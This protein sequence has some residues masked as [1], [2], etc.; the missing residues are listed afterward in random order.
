MGD[1]Q[2]W[3]PSVDHL[4]FFFVAERE[5]WFKYWPDKNGVDGDP[6]QKW[7][8]RLKGEG[9]NQSACRDGFAYLLQWKWKPRQFWSNRKETRIQ[10]RKVSAQGWERDITNWPGHESTLKLKTQ[11]SRRDWQQAP[12]Y[13]F[14]RKIFFMES[15]F[16]KGN[17]FTRAFPI[18][19]DI[20]QR[21]HENKFVEDGDNFSAGRATA[22]SIRKVLIEN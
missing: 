8:G 19:I 21:K 2:R 20:Y 1:G 15:S 17:R 6:G 5:D 13:G 10:R 14:M 16:P 22:V 11:L 7:L 9:W 3:E 18:C 4:N 12:C